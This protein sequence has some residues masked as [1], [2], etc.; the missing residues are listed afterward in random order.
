MSDIAARTKTGRN[1]PWNH[2]LASGKIESKAI[3]RTEIAQFGKKDVQPPCVCGRKTYKLNE[4]Y[5]VMCS[6]CNQPDGACDCEPL[7]HEDAILTG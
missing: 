5:P 2:G 4:N 6:N 7:T 3:G 1:R